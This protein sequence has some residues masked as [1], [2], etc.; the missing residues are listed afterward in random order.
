MIDIIKIIGIDNEIEAKIYEDL[1]L[2]NKIPYNIK[3]NHDSAY[4]GLFQMQYGW[5]YIEAP[6]KYKEQILN[7]INDYKHSK[8][9]IDNEKYNFSQEN[10]FAKN[11]KAKKLLLIFAIVNIIFLLLV[12]VN[13]DDDIN[14]SNILGIVIYCIIYGLILFFLYKGSVVVFTI[15]KMMIALSS[16]ILIL[17]FL[18]CII[19]LIIN[20]FNHQNI[21]KDLNILGL[22]SVSIILLSF[23]FYIFFLNNS[24]TYYIYY[25]KK[26]KK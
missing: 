19:D 16:L 12:F 4:D 8:K 21:Y 25:R 10:D 13:I 15:V 1:L 5:G 14:M 2:N 24:I 7:I 6:K 9:I 18:V 20:I 17:A 11:K 23:L 26:N 22:V 3:N